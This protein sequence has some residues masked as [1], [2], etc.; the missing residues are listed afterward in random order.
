MFIKLSAESAFITLS[1]FVRFSRAAENVDEFVF[2]DLLNVRSR[3]A[4]VLSG[5]EMVG[6]FN[7]MLT[8][9]RSASHT[10]I[11]IDVDFA[12]SAL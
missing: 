1:A 11:R 9:S 8:N 5:I 3:V 7:H 10:K 4:E 2:D 6:M 12:D